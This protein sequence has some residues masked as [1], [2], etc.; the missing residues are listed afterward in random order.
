M[1]DE[2]KKNARNDVEHYRALMLKA[3]QEAQV[4][5]DLRPENLMSLAKYIESLDDDTEKFR[6][7]KIP[8][9]EATI[10]NKANGATFH[11]KP[12]TPTKVKELFYD[13]ESICYQISMLT[14]QRMDDKKKA[15]LQSCHYSIIA[16]RSSLE[17]YYNEMVKALEDRDNNKEQANRNRGIGSIGINRGMF[18][19]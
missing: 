12:F 3:M 14:G 4:E 1:A 19:R 16:L 17:P 15:E 6:L 11:G 9:P 18:G 2:T 13:L 7:Q 5:D 8:N 10:I